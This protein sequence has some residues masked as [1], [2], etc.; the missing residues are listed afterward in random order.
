MGCDNFDF[1][2]TRDLNEYHIRMG[3]VVNN[4]NKNNYSR[5]GTLSFAERDFKMFNLLL[6]KLNARASIKKYRTIGF[7]SKDGPVGFLKDIE[8][9]EIDFLLFQMFIRDYWKQMTY[10]FDTNGVSIVARMYPVSF[11]RRF[12]SIFTF[13]VWLCLFATGLV[14]IITLKSTLNQSLIVSVLDFL[15]MF[16]NTPSLRE[17]L[18]SRGKIFFVIILYL[19]F[20]I[21]SYIQSRL[22]AIQTVPDYTPTIDT[23][24][25]LVKTN[26]PVFGEVH[27]REFVFHSGLR[28]RFQIIRDIHVCLQDLISEKKL[29]C[30]THCDLFVTHAYLNDEIYRA[31]SN[32]FNRPIAFTFVEDWPLAAK[33]NSL[34]RHIDEVG[35]YWLNHKNDVKNLEKAREDQ[36][37]ASLEQL[38]FCFLIFFWGCSLSV[39]TLI[40]EIVICKLRK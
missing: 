8:Q 9:G 32:L 31:K 6:E 24:D 36:S 1:D 27:H 2:K 17:P 19:I 22:S 34:L 23:P 40:V 3:T 39:C 10:P 30:L 12:I 26:L 25:D 11:A 15:R 28:R 4:I 29:V 33:V 14:L 20:E 18:N 38:T 13:R 21:S 37:T 35:I 5:S 16:T 7:I